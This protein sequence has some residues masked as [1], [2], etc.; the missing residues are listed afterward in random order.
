MTSLWT[1][2]VPAP[3]F[4]QD[5]TT[6][7]RILPPKAGLGGGKS[8]W[9]KA[10]SDCP[11]LRRPITSPIWPHRDA[12]GSQLGPAH[13]QGGSLCTSLVSP[14][15]LARGKCEASWSGT[16]LVFPGTRS[17]VADA[18]TSQGCG[19]EPSKG[20]PGVVQQSGSPSP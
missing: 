5:Q 10:G 6:F 7:S 15:H 20:G 16:F 17:R 19:G 2:R 11:F 9:I 12:Q 4:S 14:S 8:S 18:T 13:G 3:S 1:E